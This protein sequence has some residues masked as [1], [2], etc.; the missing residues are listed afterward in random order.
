MDWWKVDGGLARRALEGTGR[1][2]WGFALGLYATKWE[3]LG[4]RRE[5]E[6]SPA[7]AA[8]SIGAHPAAA[9]TYASQAL[10]AQPERASVARR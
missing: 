6:R 8:M 5:N 7:G 4:R 10:G 2:G 3:A 9:A 1:V